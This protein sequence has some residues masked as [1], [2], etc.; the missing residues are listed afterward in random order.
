MQYKIISFYSEPEP[1]S[2]YYTIHYKRFVKECEDLRLDYYVENLDGFGNYYKNC[3]LK[4][5]FILN[6]LKKFNMPLI[7]LDIDSHIKRK[8]N[9]KSFENVNFAG[10]RNKNRN[11]QLDIYAYCLFLNNNEFAINLLEDWNNNVGFNGDHISLCNI[12]RKKKIEYNDI[13]DF[14]EFAISPKYE[15]KSKII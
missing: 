6:C 7:W 2:N 12:L 13:E 3:R 9:L 10:V 5:L 4:P 8:P 1:D 14:A 11:T 15:I